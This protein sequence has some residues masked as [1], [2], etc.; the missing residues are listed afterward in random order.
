[1]NLCTDNAEILDRVRAAIERHITVGQKLPI[2]DDVKAELVSDLDR[3]ISAINSRLYLDSKSVID[4]S[5]AHIA[6][7]WT[8]VHFYHDLGDAVDAAAKQNYDRDVR[9]GLE[10]K[11]DEMD[12][13]RM[14]T[15][16]LLV[17]DG[18][19]YLPEHADH[20]HIKW[21]GFKPKE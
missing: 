19:N 8:N 15:R 16:K 7:R 6:G 18:E 11:E 10:P 1:M 2:S 20:A 9:A 12:C 13:Y 5:A 21:S 3:T 14:E 4:H 17:A